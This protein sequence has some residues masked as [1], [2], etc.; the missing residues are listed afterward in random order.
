MNGAFGKGP[1]E[2][3]AH[4]DDLSEICLTVDVLRIGSGITAGDA[5]KHIVPG[6]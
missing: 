3:R 4:C 1:G 2:L 6:G 5:K